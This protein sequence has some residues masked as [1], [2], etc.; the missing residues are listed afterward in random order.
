MTKIAFFNVRYI[1]FQVRYLCQNEIKKKKRSKPRDLIGPPDPVSNLHRVKFAIPENESKLQKKLRLHRQELQE[2]NESFWSK[3]NKRFANEKAAFEKFKLKTKNSENQ[4]ISAD[5]MSVFYK[6]FLDDNWKAHMKY[7]FTWYRKNIYVTL[8][9][10]QVFI[11][12][13]FKNR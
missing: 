9:Q 12:S 11:Q 2:W 3:H 10:F 8:L 13:S 1:L 5:E 7:L 4:T 6:Q